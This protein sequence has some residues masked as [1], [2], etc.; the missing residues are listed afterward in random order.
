MSSKALTDI[1]FL[2]SPHMKGP[3]VAHL[4]MLLKKRGFYHGLVDAELGILTHQAIWRA[5]YWVGYRK[6][7]HLAGDILISYLDGSKKPTSRMRVTRALRVKKSKQV[8]KGEL[9]VREASGHLGIKESPPGSNQVKFSQWYGMVGAWCAMFVSYVARRVGFKQFKPGVFVA[10][11]PFILAKAKLGME[12]LVIVHP[13][14]IKD[15]DV[16]CY[17]WPGESPGT[18]DHTGFFASEKTL[19]KYAPMSL[20]NAIR[21][22]GP[23]SANEFWAIEGNTAVGNNSNGGQVML[24]KRNFNTVEGIARI[25]R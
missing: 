24:R 17:D 14:S 16:L 2:H 22:F 5:K 6:P 11:V 20:Q 8:S 23:L 19:K 3:R 10:Y 15:G 21:A 12:G 25:T 9:L 18:P 7:N 13:A 4:Q 1:L